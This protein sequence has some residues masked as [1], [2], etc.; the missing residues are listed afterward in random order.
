MTLTK[1]LFDIGFA[2]LILPV[3]ALIAAVVLAA[4]ALT[5][6]RPYF[7]AAERMKT[8]DTAFRLWK[9]RTMTV[10]ATDAG[11]SG[12]D[13][14]GRITPVGRVL[15]RFRLDELP[16]LW[17]ILRG[18]ISFV[19]PRPPLRSYVERF[20]E[21]YAEV[22]KSRPGVTGLASIHYHRHEEWLLARSRSAAETDR[23]YCRICIPAKAKLDLIYARHASVCLDLRLIGR[24]IARMIS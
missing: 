17:N 4:L 1:R 19:G 23:L 7:Y 3:I 14:A 20:P 21:I 16:Q 5:Q 11:V 9:F 18:D 13:K 12:G 8:P 15:R 10:V 24:T 6:G 2:L 22:L